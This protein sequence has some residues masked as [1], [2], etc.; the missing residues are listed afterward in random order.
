MRGTA[1]GPASS[2]KLLEDVFALALCLLCLALAGSRSTFQ[3]SSNFV[4]APRWGN[5]RN[6]VFGLPDECR[7]FVVM[8]DGGQISVVLRDKLQHSFL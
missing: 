7:M 5:R 3:T 4:R 6:R 8:P 2:G 1:T